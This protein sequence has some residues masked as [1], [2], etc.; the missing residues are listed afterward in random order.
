M[1]Q[2]DVNTYLSQLFWLAVTFGFLYVLASRVIL[3]RIGQTLEARRRRITDDLEMAESLRRQAE[4]A[5]AERE[6]LLAES[7]ERA[8]QLVQAERERIT[9]ELDAR[10]RQLESEL[11]ARISRAEREL[12]QAR[13][14]ALAELQETMDELASEIARKILGRAGGRT[15]HSGREG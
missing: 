12:E 5:L 10:R 9:A 2:L 3:P 4:E 8:H 11:A 15:A 1:P 6:R 13:Q 14:A 7:R